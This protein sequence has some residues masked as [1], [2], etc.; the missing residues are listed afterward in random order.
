MGSTMIA[1]LLAT[2]NHLYLLAPYT[3]LSR[4]TRL[5][6]GR[7]LTCGGGAVRFDTPELR[8]CQ[9]VQY[10]EG[11]ILQVH[12]T[13]QVRSPLNSERGFASLAQSPPGG[14]PTIARLVGL[15]SLHLLMSCFECRA[16]GR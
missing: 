1:I 16:R 7:H 13:I 4:S 11:I 2:A 3:N 9:L 6:I 10:S 12:M 14:T 5:Y 8:H 15:H